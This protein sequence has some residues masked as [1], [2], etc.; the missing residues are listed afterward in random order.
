MGLRERKTKANKTWDKYNLG[1]AMRKT[2]EYLRSNCHMLG[3]M[4]RAPQT[5]WRVSWPPK[6]TCPW[7]SVA[8]GWQV[9]SFNSWPWVEQRKELPPCWKVGSAS[10]SAGF[11]KKEKQKRNLLGSWVR[12][13]CRR[14][15]CRDHNVQ[16]SLSTQPQLRFL[17]LWEARGCRSK[18]PAAWENKPASRGVVMCG[19]QKVGGGLGICSLG[20][21]RRMET[22]RFVR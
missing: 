18:D 2:K 7:A 20:W 9:Y 11:S 6:L 13:R 4:L 8:P 12:L 14:Q 1:L 19:V 3:R 16:Y 10:H 22:R 21:G 15:K 17:A 5:R